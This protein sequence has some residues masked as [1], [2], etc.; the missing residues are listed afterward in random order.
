[1]EDISLQAVSLWFRLLNARQDQKATRTNFDNSVK[2]R[3]VAEE[4]LKLG[5]VSRDEYLQLDLRVLNDSISL[6]DSAVRVQEAQMELNSLLGFDESAEINPVLDEELPDLTLEY[7]MVL[8]KSLNNLSF[9]LDNELRLLEARSAVEKA[10]AQRGVTMNLNARFGLSKSGITLPEAYRSPLD[11]EV[12]GLGFSFPI[13]DWGQ[14]KGRIEKARAAEQVAMAKVQQAESDFRRTI[15]TAVAQFNHQRSQC[16]VSRRA[17]AIS[18]ERYMLVMDRF[19]AGNATVLELNTARN[20]SDQ[21]RNQYLTDL[22]NYWTYYYTLRR[23]ALYDYIQGE[24][25]VLDENE[26]ARYEEK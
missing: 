11:Q 17:A 8:N 25:I 10:K 23:Y 9:F 13:F 15:F 4:R 16:E 12:L 21:A 5:T 3:D 6:N 14:G 24:D 2:M 22:G 26:L 19:R 20:E 18:A 7:E 1:M